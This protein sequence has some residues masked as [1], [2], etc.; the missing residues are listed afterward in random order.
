MDNGAGFEILP[1]PLD[2]IVISQIKI[3]TTETVHI[4]AWRPSSRALDEV[5]PN[6]SCRPGDNDT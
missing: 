6:Q 5:L 3:N 2:R 4:P 1:G